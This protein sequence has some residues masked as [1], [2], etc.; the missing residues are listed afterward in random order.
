MDSQVKLSVLLMILVCWASPL[1]G[2]TWYIQGGTIFTGD[3]QVIEEGIIRI[4]DGEITYV[5]ISLSPPK[6]AL[7]LEAK[8]KFI[9][10]GFILANTR[11]GVPREHPGDA[12]S[13]REVT[14]GFRVFDVINPEHPGFQTAV[15]Y[16]VTTVNVMPISRRPVPGVG[17]IIKTGGGPLTERVINPASALA[18]NLVQKNDVEKVRQASRG[19]A[20]EV[21]AILEIREALTEAVRTKTTFEQGEDTPRTPVVNGHTAMLIRALNQ[22]MP[23][24]I[25]ARTS[26]EIERGMSLYED[27]R[28]RP[29]F[30]QPRITE[31]VW[32][33]FRSSQ[34]PVIIGPLSTPKTLPAGYQDPLRLFRHLRTYD[35]Q[36]HLQ[37]NGVS[38]A[39]HGRVHQLRY[40]AAQLLQAGFSAQDVLSTLS[41]VPAE[42]LGISHRTGT[43][44]IGNDADLNI[45]GAHPFQDL[46]PPDIVIIDGEVVTKPNRS[47]R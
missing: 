33:R 5:G 4:E 7:V 23:T 31:P 45:F 43:I 10:P 36:F 42:L 41:L 40:Q 3:G 17:A 46:A 12:L 34:F 8:E 15:R 28:F 18:V 22:E 14:P 38:R 1:P 37:I 47:N 20:S 44:E 29:V 35:L 6:D 25:Y 32:E 16:G 39:E 9:T 13:D 21:A 24:F 27:Y 19:F 2:M 11:I 30:I 26:T